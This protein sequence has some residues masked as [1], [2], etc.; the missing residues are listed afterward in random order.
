MNNILLPCLPSFE[1]LL[2]CLFFLILP[3]KPPP[4]GFYVGPTGDL[5]V[6]TS[7]GVAVCVH[8]TTNVCTTGYDT[9]KL[10]C[11]APAAG[12]VIDSTGFACTSQGAAVCAQDAT[13]C[14][15]GKDTTKIQC[16]VAAGGYYVDAK[17]FA[18]T[19][20]PQSTNQPKH[21]TGPAQ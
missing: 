21:K 5:Q 20:P 2:S 14:T 18:N 3:S 15:I 13:M 6:C 12:Y 10:L 17:G 8:D 16:E 7:Q 11:T 1:N 4:P 9:T 19:L